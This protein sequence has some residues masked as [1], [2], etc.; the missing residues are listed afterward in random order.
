MESFIISTLMLGIM[1]QI[2]TFGEKVE[3][4]EQVDRDM[5]AEIDGADTGLGVSLPRTS[6]QSQLV[7]NLDKVFGDKHF[8][9]VGFYTLA[10]KGNT[11]MKGASQGQRYMVVGP[12]R[13][14]HGCP[15]IP[16]N[17]GVCGYAARSREI[18]IVDDTHNWQSPDGIGEH[19]ACDSAS[20]SE[21]VVPIISRNGSL[22]G[23]LDCDSSEYAAFDQTDKNWLDSLVRKYIAPQV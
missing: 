5:R 12:Y 4:Y 8:F 22:I 10:G 13:G 21:I 3:R 17:N 20:N 1:A 14:S 6:R 7:L 11:I 9:W 16:L 23:V 2:Y 19:I 18:V 15:V